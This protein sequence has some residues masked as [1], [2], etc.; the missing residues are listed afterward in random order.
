MIHDAIKEGDEEFL[1]E[2]LEA[3]NKKY[4]QSEDSLEA[5]VKREDKTERNICIEEETT[6]Y[7][8]RKESENI[9]E[10]SNQESSEEHLVE[11]DTKGTQNEEESKESLEKDKVEDENSNSDER[12]VEDEPEGKK[13]QSEALATNLQELENAFVHFA[14]NTKD[15]KTS[16]NHEKELSNKEAI[17]ECLRKVLDMKDTIGDLKNEVIAGDTKKESRLWDAPNE[18]GETPLLVTTSLNK[19]VLT[20]MLLNCNP[21]VNIQN[22]DGDTALHNTARHEAIEEATRIIEMGG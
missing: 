10:A 9:I 22:A 19:S 11:E 12:R 1:A 18:I 15:G 21:N 20:N 8:N 17:S 6:N 16:E 5:Y 2:V 3:L 14:R 4:G 7:G 13:G